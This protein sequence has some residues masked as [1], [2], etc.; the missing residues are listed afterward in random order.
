MAQH[1]RVLAALPGDLGSI[2]SSQ[3]SVT[4]VPGDLCLVF[5]GTAHTWYTDMHA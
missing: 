5:Q 1:L 4:T 2:P 3:L